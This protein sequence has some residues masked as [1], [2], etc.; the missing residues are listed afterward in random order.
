MQRQGGCQ[1]P[2]VAR[3]PIRNMCFGVPNFLT[4]RKVH[5]YA[6]SHHRRY[7]R[8][9]TQAAVMHRPPRHARLR[10]ENGIWANHQPAKNNISSIFITPPVYCREHEHTTDSMALAFRCRHYPS[11]QTKAATDNIIKKAGQEEKIRLQTAYLELSKDDGGL[12]SVAAHIPDPAIFSTFDRGTNLQNIGECGTH[13]ELLEAF[14]IL[15]QRVLTSNSLDR[16]FGIVPKRTVRMGFGRRRRATVEP[17]GTFQD[18]REIKWAIFILLAAARF[19]RWWHSVPE[20]LEAN[21]GAGGMQL[22]AQTMPPLGRCL[23]SFTVR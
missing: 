22:D 10:R 17:D 13:L 12:A 6:L 14:V 11:G 23:N 5:V 21:G 1:P 7:A 2:A 20:I 19:R 18:R 9:K 16:A 4:D 8:V 15:Q 3:F